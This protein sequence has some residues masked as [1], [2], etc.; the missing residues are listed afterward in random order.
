MSTET[1]T[2]AVAAEVDCLKAVSFDVV[3]NNNGNEV[4][5]A[6]VSLEDSLESGF[7][8]RLSGSTSGS[9]SVGGSTL[10]S[11]TLASL[12]APPASTEP[13]EEER[14]AWEQEMRKVEEEMVTLRLVLQVI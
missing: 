12:D 6:N 14:L 8:G 11:P 10:G 2:V 1:V 3:E 9:S 7:D 13:T 5:D 4:D